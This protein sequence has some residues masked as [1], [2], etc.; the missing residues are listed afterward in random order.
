MQ[1]SGAF[2][3]YHINEL[4]ALLSKEVSIGRQQLISPVAVVSLYSLSYFTLWIY[5]Q[6]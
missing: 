5:T 1:G 6:E 3:S 4:H 2:T